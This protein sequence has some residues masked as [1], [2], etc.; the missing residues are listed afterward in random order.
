M[1]KNFHPANIKKKILRFNINMINLSLDELK[2]V[3]QSRNI[4]D[5]ENKSKKDLIKVL[6]KPK[7]KIKINKKELE[8]IRKDFHKLR[9]KFSK[10]EIGKYR[11]A[12][13][14]IKSYS[15]LSASEIKKARKKLTKLKKSLRFKKFYGDIDTVDYDDLDNYDY[16]YD[17]GDDDDDEYKKTGSIRRLFKGFDRD[18]YKPIRTDYDFGGINNYIEQTTRGDRYENLSPEEYL[19]IIRPY[20][21]DLINNHKPTTELNNNANNNV[22]NNVIASNAK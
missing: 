8:E 9:H 16:N 13:Y 22:N 4:R 21:R 7:P 3:A 6:S 18:Y 1:N 15:Y 19:K 11:E 20:L 5:Y 10:K 14:D 17:D 12:F 2:L